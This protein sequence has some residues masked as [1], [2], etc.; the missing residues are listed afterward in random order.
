MSTVRPVRTPSPRVS[1]NQS[2]GLWAFA[3]RKTEVL[4][5]GAPMVTTNLTI[6]I[7]GL[8]TRPDFSGQRPCKRSTYEKCFENRDE[9]YPLSFCE[10]ARN[11]KR[12]I[13]EA[14]LGSPNAL[15][16]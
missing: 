14:P 13:R 3:L 5:T 10:I 2:D 7:K 8:H 15:V 1:H 9:N 16:F 12:D 11:A 4:S 6:P